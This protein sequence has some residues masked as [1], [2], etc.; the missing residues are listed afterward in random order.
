MSISYGRS[1][2]KS[3]NDC[4]EKIMGTTVYMGC[5]FCYSKC[6]KIG[7]HSPKRAILGAQDS[8]KIAPASYLGLFWAP[9]GVIKSSR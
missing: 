2:K 1:S 9:I 5:M 4:L 7:Q 8:S 3:N 6:V